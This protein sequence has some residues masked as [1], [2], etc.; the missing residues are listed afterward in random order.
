MPTRADFYVGRGA[1]AE[2]LGSIAFDLRQDAIDHATTIGKS[3]VEDELALVAPARGKGK[4]IRQVM[5]ELE[6]AG[7][8][9]IETVE[10]MTIT[11]P[12]L[13]QSK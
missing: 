2:W 4:M 5:E 8:I 12:L 7:C 13:E 3:K 1:D 11:K 9:R 10:K 6:D